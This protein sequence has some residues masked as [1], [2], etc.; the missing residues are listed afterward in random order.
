MK[1]WLKILIG[2]FLGALTG[3]GLSMGGFAEY[4]APFRHIADVFMNLIR[5]LIALLILSSMTVGVTSIHDPKKLG[6][7][8]LKSL[9]LYFITTVIAICI[10]LFFA[11]LLRPGVGVQLPM[12]QTVD[13]GNLPPLTDILVNIVPSN[14]IASLAEGNALQI[15]VFAI[16]LGLAINAAGDRGRPLLRFLESIAD[17]MYKLTEIVMEIAPFGVFAIMVWVV[18]SFGV[19]VLGSLVEFLF[20]NYLACLVHM[21]IVFGGLLIFVAKLNPWS[22]FKGMGDAILLA[23]STNSSSATLP[24]SLHCVQENLGVSKNVA[25]FV[26]PLGSTVN[27]NGAAI[28]QAISAVFVSQA[29][30]IELGWHSIIMVVVTA[31]LSAVGAAGVPGTTIVMLTV[32]LGSVGLPLEGILLISGVDRVREMVTT[33]VNILGDSVVA[34]YI[35]KTEGELNEDQYNHAHLVEMEESDV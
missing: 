14:P 31:T 35:A 25:N 32:V 1:L 29:Y 20:C 27:M 6:R 15:I 24:V 5:M 7:V 8:G 34:V 4:A 17:V 3:W 21:V 10:G 13:V 26:L 33:V 22:F 18:G 12:T 2:L 16:F 19:K 11:Y 9:G 28:S 30:G 23:F